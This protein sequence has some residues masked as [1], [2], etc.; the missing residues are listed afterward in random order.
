M[1]SLRSVAAV[2][3]LAVFMEFGCGGQPSTEPGLD[4]GTSGNRAPAVIVWSGSENMGLEPIVKEYALSK[5]VTIQVKYHGSI[6]IMREIRKGHL[7][8]PDILWPA[9]SHWLA[10]GDTAKV[11]HY[12]ESIM[13]SPLVVAVKLSKAESLGW[14]PNR[15]N[16]IRREVTVEDVLNATSA[17]TLRLGMTSATQSN[18]GNQAYLGFLY[19]FA[20]KPEMLEMKHL[21]DPAV[22]AK[23][24]KLL[25][26]FNR[27]AGSSGFLKDLLVE[28]YDSLD[29][30]VNYECLVIEANEQLVA[31]GQEPLF[32][33]YVSDGTAIADS[34]L[35]LVDKSDAR[36]EE[37][38]RG[39]QTYLLS[40][41]V[42]Q[43][44]LQSGRRT[45]KVGLAVSGAVAR[46]NPAWGIDVPPHHFASTASAQRRHSRGDEP[47]SD[48]VSQAVVDSLRPR[49]LGV[50]GAKRWGAAAQ[51][52]HADSAE[53]ASGS[54]VSASAESTGRVHLHPVQQRRRLA[55]HREWKR[56][57]TP[58]GS[59]RP[60]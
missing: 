32:A 41:A 24:S 3:S 52:R 9:A 1:R 16:S 7:A 51:G 25:R 29:G 6:D 48:G 55:H 23:V 49:L 18:S 17:G 57:T 39:L 54:R 45:G 15:P 34:P 42:Q 58:G 40:E 11:V 33:V 10:I 13:K 14:V 43:R 27:S 38:F 56:P 28:R 20:G 30:M 44:I 8:E 12:A 19:A 35:A 26:S 22:G 50:D 46:F 5:G 36:K 47:L 59:L 31:Q 53:P 60:A 37:I 21:Q 2:C 4:A